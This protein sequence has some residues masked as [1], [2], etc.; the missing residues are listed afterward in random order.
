MA[1]VRISIVIA[2]Q[3]RTLGQRNNRMLTI[4]LIISVTGLSVCQVQLCFLLRKLSSHNFLS[5]LLGVKLVLVVV[6]WRHS[7]SVFLVSLMVC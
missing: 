5:V 2:P 6:S 1:I 7:I 3:Y 4:I